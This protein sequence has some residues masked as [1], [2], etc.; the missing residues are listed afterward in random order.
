MTEPRLAGSRNEVEVAH[1]K[2]IGHWPRLRE[3]LNADRT[4]L[5]LRESIRQAA[6]A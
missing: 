3:W 5:L 1:E 2:L 4:A 6:R